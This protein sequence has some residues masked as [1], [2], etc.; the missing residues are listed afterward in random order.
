MSNYIRQFFQRKREV[1]QKGWEIKQKKMGQKRLTR[2]RKN[3][4]R[5]KIEG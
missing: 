1:R 5:G 3:R 2:S 4:G